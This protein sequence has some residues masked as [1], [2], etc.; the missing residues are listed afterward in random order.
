MVLSL[1]PRGK[2]VL[3]LLRYMGLST[4]TSRSPGA[5]KACPRD[6]E[7]FFK[8][9]SRTLEKEKN[10]FNVSQHFA[11]SSPS[12]SSHNNSYYHSPTQ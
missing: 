5:H 12:T 6:S 7:T 2:K 8:Q 3:L 11:R 10:L 9:K 4:K 1:T